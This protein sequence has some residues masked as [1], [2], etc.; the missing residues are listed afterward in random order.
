MSIRH[1]PRQARPW[2]RPAWYELLPEVVLIGGL[3]LFLID[4]PDAATSAFKSGRAVTL[5]LAAGVTWVIA[6]LALARWIRW[7]LGRTVMFGLAAVAVLA[8]VVLPAYDDETVVE[9]FPVQNPEAPATTIPPPA[10]PAPTEQATTPAAAPPPTTLSPPPATTMTTTSPTAAEEPVRLRSA[11]FTGIDHRASGTVSIY[12]APDGRHVVGLE[13]F[14]I[15]PGPDYDVYVVPGTDRH[16]PDDGVRLDD[17]RGNQGTQYYDVPTDVDV[18]DGA[19][20]V[21]IWCQT[22]GVPVANATPI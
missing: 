21:L 22:F 18:G 2:R 11:P 3:T 12:R 15:Q 13:T 17:L 4:E 6:R 16:A 20:T 14:D 9:A 7:P 8:V 19:W 10:T 5:M 1:D